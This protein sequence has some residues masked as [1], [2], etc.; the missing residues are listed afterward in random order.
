[1]VQLTHELTS[2]AIRI[3]S[4]PTCENIARTLSS[5]HCEAEEDRANVLR[6]LIR[7]KNNKIYFLDIPLWT[8]TTQ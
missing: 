6:L 7:G 5:L 2:T 1:M 3:V 4:L 8:H